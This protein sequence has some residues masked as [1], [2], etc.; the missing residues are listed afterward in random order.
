MIELTGEEKMRARLLA[1]ANK[2]PEICEAALYEEA[3][4]EMTESMKRTPVDKGPLRASHTVETKRRGSD[5]SATIGVGGPSAPYAVYVHE[6]EDA[7]H[8]VGQAK[9][10]ESTILESRPYMALRIATRI[11]AKLRGV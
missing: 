7:F 3:H 10:L 4:I 11:K 2:I 1:Y 9:F 8:K 6:D 5:I